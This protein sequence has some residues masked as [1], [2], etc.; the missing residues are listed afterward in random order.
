MQPEVNA[1]TFDIILVLRERP[2]GLSGLCLYQT[3]L[4]DP[5]T[6]KQMLEDFQDVLARLTSQPERRLSTFRALGGVGG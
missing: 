1:T 6:I 2:Q 4:F 5:A 3:S